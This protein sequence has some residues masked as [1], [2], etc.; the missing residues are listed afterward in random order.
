MTDTISNFATAFTSLKAATDAAEKMAAANDEAARKQLQ[1]EILAQVSH[2]YSALHSAQDERSELLARIRQLESIEVIKERYRL[3]SLGAQGV[4]AF[5]PK[6][7]DPG[8]AE[9]HLCGNC[10]NAGKASYLQQTGHGPYVLTWHC[11]TCGEKLTVDTGRPRQTSTL[12]DRYN[13]GP[14]GWMR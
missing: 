4:V 7:P 10:L 1:N 12:P 9:H 14:Q 6:Q 13:T 11:N 8:E 5:A 3:V 2:A